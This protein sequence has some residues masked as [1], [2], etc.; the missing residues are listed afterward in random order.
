[1]KRHAWYR[2]CLW[3]RQTPEV[4][5]R[6][7]APPTRSTYFRIARL[8]EPLGKAFDDAGAPLRVYRFVAWGEDADAIARRYALIL[9]LR[10]ELGIWPLDEQMSQGVEPCPAPAEPAQ[11]EADAPELGETR[12][13]TA[14]G[15]SRPPPGDKRRAA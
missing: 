11:D 9:T 1:M 10:E 7:V 13:P 3:Y 12:E 6:L 4:M 15:P 5:R 8:P 14:A 2:F